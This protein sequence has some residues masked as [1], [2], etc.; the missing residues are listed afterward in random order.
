MAWYICLKFRKE[1]KWDLGV[2]RYKK[3]ITDLGHSGRL[4]IY[5]NSS[6][7]YVNPGI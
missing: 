5:V 1:Y 3:I 7:I 4:K 2:D 6:N